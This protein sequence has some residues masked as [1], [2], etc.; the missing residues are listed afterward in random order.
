MPPT[1]S[2]AASSY[3]PERRS[4]QVIATRDE[5]KAKAFAQQWRGGAD[6]ATMQAAAKTDG[7]TAAEL[8]KASAAEIPVPDLAKAVFATPADTVSGPL[9]SPL[10][11]HVFK[12]TAVSPAPER[13]FDEVKDELRSRCL[14]TT[15]RT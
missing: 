12:V 9:H 10:G 4:V 6:W 15:R 8:D 5:A 1:T 7:A 3:Q 14:P 11:W 2:G 13:T